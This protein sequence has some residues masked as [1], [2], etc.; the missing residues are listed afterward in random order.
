MHWSAT[1]GG[2][3]VYLE[4]GRIK[5]KSLSCVISGYLRGC[6]NHGESMESPRHDTLLVSR[7]EFFSVVNTVV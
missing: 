6:D 7:G 1:P 3:A 5:Y 2:P 4:A